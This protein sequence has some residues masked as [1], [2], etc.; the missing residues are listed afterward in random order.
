MHALQFI[1]L[2][3]E[4]LMPENITRNNRKDRNCNR[5]DIIM[6]DTLTIINENG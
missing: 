2:I 6:L 5:K 1:I 3:V 4:N